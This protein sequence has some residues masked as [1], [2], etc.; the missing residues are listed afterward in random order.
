MNGAGYPRQRDHNDAAP[1]S[2]RF[3]GGQRRGPDVGMLSPPL[4]PQNTQP[5]NRAE[6]FEDEKRRIIESCFNKLDKTGQ[7]KQKL[8]Y[9]N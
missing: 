4:P 5:L 7:G 3:P 1:P 2:A 6:R 8:N 9:R